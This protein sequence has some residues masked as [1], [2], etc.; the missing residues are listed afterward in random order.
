MTREEY[1]QLKKEG[2]SIYMQEFFDYYKECGGRITDENEFVK[3]FKNLVEGNRV[4]VGSDGRPKGVSVINAT[5]RF[6][7]YYDRKFGI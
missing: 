2:R 1:I 5:N 6:Y 7:D 3:I 4:V